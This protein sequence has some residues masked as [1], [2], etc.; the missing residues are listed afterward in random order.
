MSIMSQDTS[1]KPQDRQDALEK[2]VPKLDLCKQIP[3][4]AFENSALV[5]SY[6]CDKRKTE[7]FIEERDCIDFCRR[8]MVNAPPVYPAPTL[9]EIMEACPDCFSRRYPKAK[10]KWGVVFLRKRGLVE[11]VEFDDKNPATAA[12]KLWMVLNKTD[13]SDKSDQSDEM[14]TD[15]KGGEK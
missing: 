8:N 6:S 12:L 4:G 5:W 3:P 15:R 14:D 1:F 10:P 9:A 2:L 13:K 11:D 7:P